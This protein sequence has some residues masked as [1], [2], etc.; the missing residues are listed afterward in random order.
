MKVHRH[1]ALAA[2]LAVAGTAMAAGDPL[3][4]ALEESKATG[5]GLMMY[6]AGQA[7]AG[8]V[9]TVD[10]RYVVARSQDKGTIVIRLDRLDGVAGFVSIE[11]KP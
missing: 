3:R 8:V 6:V 2:A 7:I 1:L 11:R 9:V 10:D 4:T 5:K